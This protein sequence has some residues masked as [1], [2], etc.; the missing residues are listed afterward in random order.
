[1]FD[2]FQTK[3]KLE[4]EDEITQRQ[5][6]L[7][8]EIDKG[9]KGFFYGDLEKD[10]EYVKMQKENSISNAGGKSNSF[11]FIDHS[12]IHIDFEKVKFNSK[13]MISR[14][15]YG[16]V[17]KLTDGVIYDD[18][19][20]VKKMPN[21]FGVDFV[22]PFLPKMFHKEVIAF[23]FLS[24]YGVVPK[25]IFADYDKRFYVMEKLDKTLNDI[26]KDCEFETRHVSAFIDL[27]CRITLTP[28]RHNDFHSNNVM[29]SESQGRFFFIDWGLYSLLGNS[30]PL[31]NY[32]Y[33]SKRMPDLDSDTKV[34][35]KKGQ[36]ENV[37]I[38]GYA[39]HLVN[40]YLKYLMEK[41]PE[42]WNE[43]STEFEEYSTIATDEEDFDR[44]H[45]ESFIKGE[46]SYWEKQCAKK[47]QGAAGLKRN[48]ATKKSKNK[49]KRKGSK[50]KG[51]K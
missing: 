7:I 31:K 51:K 26:I 27:M 38:R 11:E 36:P 46:I 22:N 1:M 35:H 33:L 5:L 34:Y 20:V 23:R 14:G 17:Y 40:Y 25:I 10:K 29:W 43:A 3:K 49:N 42:K 6:D 48:K 50:K 32:E 18:R 39:N 19:Y 8:A 4:A 12:D 16:K 30:K 15:A 41:E 37:L 47:K 13:D 44:E 45:Y 9:K 24:D 28:Y 21:F 2:F